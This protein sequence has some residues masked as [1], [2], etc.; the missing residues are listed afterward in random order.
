MRTSQP[1][2]GQ[3][4][5]TETESVTKINPTKKSPGPDGFTA[6][7]YQTFQ[8]LIPILHNPFKT[9]E[10]KGILPNPFMR[11]TSP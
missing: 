8:E 5:A 11:P 9:T 10:R 7:F 4:T 6:K 3:L 2:T 1:Y